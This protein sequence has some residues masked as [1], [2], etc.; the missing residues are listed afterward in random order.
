MKKVILFIIMGL[1]VLGLI[2]NALYPETEE[3][4]STQVLK[5]NKIKI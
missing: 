2:G 4:K 3:Q 5:D 1:I